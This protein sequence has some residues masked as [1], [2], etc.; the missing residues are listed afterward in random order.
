MGFKLWFPCS[1]KSP[2]LYQMD[3]YLG[4]NQTLEYYVG[5]GEEVVLQL[6]KELE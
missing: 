1:N 3:I 5:P 4:R 2:Y 6:T